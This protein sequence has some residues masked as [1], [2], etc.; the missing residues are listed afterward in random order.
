V[1][2]FDLVLAIMVLAG[3]LFVARRQFPVYDGQSYS[4]TSQSASPSPA[5]TS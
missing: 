5:P 3:L 1:R 2:F 4:P